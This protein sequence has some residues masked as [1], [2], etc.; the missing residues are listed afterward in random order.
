MELAGWTND[1]LVEDR[2][3][4]L[5]E[6][7]WVY[8]RPNSS[9]VMAS[10]LH[11]APAGGRFHGPDLGAWYASAELRTAAFEVAH[12]LRREAVATGARTLQRDYRTYTAELSGSY[13]DV[14]GRQAEW[15]EIYDP[16]SYA[17][18]QTFGER[19]RSSGG[20]GIIYDSVR[21][22]GGVNVVGYRP[23]QILNVTQTNHWRIGVEAASPRIHMERLTGS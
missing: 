5:P 22:I 19:V 3:R 2:L 7:E 20:A 17:A 15:T 14:R 8:G 4:R 10:F 23:Q 12:H 13:L 21:H 11:V 16:A 9:V 18:S 6:A 1:R